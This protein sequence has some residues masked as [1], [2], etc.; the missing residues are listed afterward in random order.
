MAASRREQYEFHHIIRP[1]PKRHD[2]VAGESTD[3]A[4]IYFIPHPSSPNKPNPFSHISLFNIFLWIIDLGTHIHGALWRSACIPSSCDSQTGTEIPIYRY[5]ILVTAFEPS[6]HSIAKYPIGCWESSSY[7]EFFRTIGFRNSH[8]RSQLPKPRD[9]A[10]VRCH[11]RYRRHPLNC[12]IF[13]ILLPISR[14]VLCQQKNTVRFQLLLKSSDCRQG[15]KPRKPLTF[16]SHG[17]Q[18]AKVFGE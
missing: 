12:I 1:W 2:V 8:P 10:I 14:R 4:H 3:F 15:N 9:L 5:T 18:Y 7:S 6:Q 11:H 13:Q 17:S 16:N